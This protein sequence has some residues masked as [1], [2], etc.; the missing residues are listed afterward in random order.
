MAVAPN[1]PGF[2]NS[3][4]PAIDPGVGKT[5][6]TFA[7]LLGFVTAAIVYMGVSWT[8]KPTETFIPRA[9]MP[10]EVYDAEENEGDLSSGHVD[11]V[12][13]TTKEKV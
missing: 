1:L 5:P 6:Y 9:I 13:D 3:V 2:I 7:W 4:N 8:W 11:V 10:D 12:T